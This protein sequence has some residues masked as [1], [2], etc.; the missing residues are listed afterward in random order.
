MKR[1]ALITLL[2]VIFLIVLAVII[3]FVAYRNRVT[4]TSSQRPQA[5]GWVADSPVEGLRGACLSYTFN[6][7]TSGPIY[8]TLN[9]EILDNLSGKTVGQCLPENQLAAAKMNYTCSDAACLTPTNTLA[10]TQTLY[11][12]CTEV[13][14]QCEGDLVL[15]VLDALAVNTQKCLTNTLTLAT[16][17]VQTDTQFF[18]LQRREQ[19]VR[20]ITYASIQTTNLICLTV[21]D[22]L[23]ECP[24]SAC[25]S[26]TLYRTPVLRSIAVVPNEGYVWLLKEGQNN[27]DASNARLPAPGASPSAYAG[28]GFPYQ[29]IVYA[30][31]GAGT[32]EPIPDGLAFFAWLNDNDGGVLDV[33][34]NGDVAVWSN[35][36]AS[37]CLTPNKLLYW[38]TYR[39]DIRNPACSYARSVNC[40]SL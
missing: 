9:T 4:R 37:E 6:G 5:A 12:M 10:D 33:G 14:K 8:P 18:Y 11:I 29:K 17:S 30:G 26:R 27:I 16:C 36:G 24:S 25:S 2:V 21:G 39:D 32:K 28:V 40:S 1:D 13:G 23:R 22:N 3:S 31:T 7:T 34:C 19:F 38:S 20:F 15:I 35:F